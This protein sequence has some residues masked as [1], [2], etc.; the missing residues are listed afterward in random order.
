MQLLGVLENP[1]WWVR[2]PASEPQEEKEKEK[3]EEKEKEKE[4]EE[5]VPASVVNGG[6]DSE[7][8]VPTFPIY[9]L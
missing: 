1:S 5:R 3:E 8:G 7:L 9:S 4:R 6:S 2:P